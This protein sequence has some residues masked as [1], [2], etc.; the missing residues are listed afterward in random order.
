MLLQV[1]SAS[2][3]RTGGRRRAFQRDPRPD[4][5]TADPRIRP[6]GRQLQAG[7]V[8]RSALSPAS[9]WATCRIRPREKYF[10]A[11]LKETIDV[12][13]KPFRVVQELA[14]D[15]SAAGRAALKG[16]STVVVQGT[17]SYQACDDKICFSAAHGPDV[18]DRYREGVVMNA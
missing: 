3:R 10:Y 2:V 6:D 7:R 17:L 12:C 15:G 8:Q 14:L 11:P 4:A 18:V 5:R 13:Q 1:V 16:M 9:S